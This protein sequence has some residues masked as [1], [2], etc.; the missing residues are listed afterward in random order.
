MAPETSSSVGHHLEQHHQQHY[1]G[2]HD[3]T[4]HQQRHQQPEHGSLKDPRLRLKTYKRVSKALPPDPLTLHKQRVMKSLTTQSK[5]QDH[6][7][8]HF[9]QPPAPNP[10]PYLHPTA[11]GSSLYQNQELDSTPPGVKP[12]SPPPTKKGLV[13]DRPYSFY[14]VASPTVPQSVTVIDSPFDP[15]PTTTAPISPYFTKPGQNPFNP[16]PQPSH[17]PQQQQIKFISTG[18]PEEHHQRK[19]RP[20]PEDSI[21]TRSMP[22]AVTSLTETYV[23]LDGRKLARERS[24]SGQNRTIPRLEKKPSVIAT[25]TNG[26]VSR[27]P[28][29]D[30][31]ERS[32][33][34]SR[35]NIKG[36]DQDAVAPSTEIPAR[37]GSGTNLFR[38]A[39]Q[40]SD[41]AFR[42]VGLNRKVSEKRQ[43]ADVN[44]EAPRQHEQDTI[45]T[46][47]RAR[48]SSRGA[49]ETTVTFKLAQLQPRE[50]EYRYPRTH[51]AELGRNRS[52]PDIKP[53]SSNDRTPVRGSSLTNP[54][55]NLG[56]FHSRQKSQHQLHTTTSTT[57]STLQ[58]AYG[59]TT[60]DWRQAQQ[61][62]KEASDRQKLKDSSPTERPG[63]TSINSVSTL[64]LP[65][66]TTPLTSAAQTNKSTSRILLPDR[67]RGGSHTNDMG[68]YVASSTSQS[69]I[70]D[71]PI[72]EPTQENT[73]LAKAT[74]QPGGILSQLQA[75]TESGHV[76]DP[77]A[78][79]WSAKEGR[80][81]QRSNT[82]PY[83]LRETR[84]ILEEDEVDSDQRSRAPLEYSRSEGSSR[85]P[86]T[87]KPRTQDKEGPQ[88]E[89]Q[90]TLEASTS[91]LNHQPSHQ[92]LAPNSYKQ[93]HVNQPVYQQTF[94][95]VP[96]HLHLQQIQ[97]HHQQ[98]RSIVMSRARALSNDSAM[99]AGLS[100]N[101]D[102]PPTP[103]GTPASQAQ[104]NSATQDV[105]VLPVMESDHS[106]QHRDSELRSQ[107]SH[108]PSSGH[109]GRSE[110]QPESSRHG[111]HKHQYQQH[112]NAPSGW[113]GGAPTSEESV[114]ALSRSMSPPP[115][116]SNRL[117]SH[118][119]TGSNSQ[120]QRGASSGHV[121]GAAQ[122]A[123]FG[124]DMLPLPVIPSPDQTL[125]KDAPLGILPQDVLKTLDP[126]TV[127]KAINT[128]VI[129]SRI[130]KVLSADELESLK[131]EQDDLQKYIEALNISLTIE[132]RMRDASHSL[133]RL[134]ENNTNIEAVK[135]STGQLHAT[136][137]K[138]DQ[139]VQKSQQSQ[140]RLLVIQRILLQHEGAVLNAGMRRLDAENR[141][142]SRSVLEL[143]TIRDQEKE[144]KL[145]WKKEH[146][147]LRIQ[148]MIFPN[149]PGVEGLES[150]RP[151]GDNEMYLQVGSEPTNDRRSPMQHQMLQQRQQEQLQKEQ[152]ERL[153]A[154]ENYMKE[155]NEDI[156]KKDERVQ[157]LESQLRL[158]EA[159]LDDFSSSAQQHIGPGVDLL[160]DASQSEGQEYSLQ[161]KMQR[162]QLK[163]ENGFRTLE[164]DMYQLRSKAEVAEE[165][166]NA[167]LEFTAMTLA[168]SAEHNTS[169]H[170]SPS[171][172]QN[173]AN[174]S[175]HLR[176]TRSR[177]ND[178]SHTH[179]PSSG[180]S[181][182]REPGARYRAYPSDQ[183][184]PSNTDLNML[185]N[186][187][188][189]EL[190]LQLSM[191]NSH[192]SN[193]RHR[194]HNHHQNNSFSEDTSS[195]GSS[196][197]APTV[198]DQVGANSG[199]LTRNN[200]VSESKL[201]PRLGLN[202]SVSRTKPQ[203]QQPISPEAQ[204]D[205][206]V[207]GDA[208]EEIR[209][210]NAMV[211][212][213]ERLVQMKLQ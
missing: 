78:G 6:H 74:V 93:S 64:N 192:S 109:R 10:L 85:Y 86:R 135:A 70:H 106:H 99:E 29:E 7:N 32:L 35:G 110:S 159:W 16:L 183:Q 179:D 210:L 47:S 42:S 92:P 160:L 193:N 23:G 27:R 207:I 119:R 198:Y 116:P 171:Q 197:T 175:T 58:D 111:H 136:T 196:S 177:R 40:A 213:L 163:I 153:N 50:Q 1:N 137:R 134:H 60:D 154:L 81:I 143:E 56:R 84:T 77:A 3:A 107:R 125:N 148:S 194:N 102:L 168:N 98:Q 49:I 117:I 203:Q 66:T 95:Q 156:N 90:P 178:P 25:H 55:T 11:S 100:S 28:F 103:Q 88:P 61:A 65:P 133:I 127:Q 14:K 2:A 13:I 152:Q 34:T 204:K 201:Q 126:K 21:A 71:S 146:S 209:R 72:P 18:T 80:Y 24:T 176:R 83:S 166:K 96:D 158:V 139:I 200:S 199:H 57:S 48:S 30:P 54:R 189:L 142:L 33:S 191:D 79:I 140:E 141:E 144:E 208:H 108:T 132:T 44:V 211:D 9:P 43:N 12:Y 172:G 91:R 151:K 31:P 97:N 51:D 87:Q 19:D 162:L 45:H 20:Y 165:A 180:T 41:S 94:P 130:Y 188:L 212:E 155:L 104:S 190:D 170:Y 182:Y 112:H 67:D 206:L 122:K 26:Q 46:Q 76:I 124:I 38:I 167:A 59:G 128:S 205:G 82:A 5:P 8:H 73:S 114:L 157:D 37:K 138:M 195:S 149:P 62:E 145:K 36:R 185:L 75:A 105:S 118:E 169:G 147:Q 22:P 123:R 17:T 63:H 173:E 187:S 69:L 4:R 120:L 39:R 53:P 161:S 68:R 89:M 184:H 115:P 186:D 174:G 15:P 113:K 121:A 129:A 181:R 131:K 52:L 150:V 164:R 101:K 202:R